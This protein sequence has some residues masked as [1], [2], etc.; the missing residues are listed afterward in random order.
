MENKGFT[1][2]HHPPHTHPPIQH[3]TVISNVKLAAAEDET[4]NNL[5]AVKLN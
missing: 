4:F 2:H 3:P 1:R 5:P